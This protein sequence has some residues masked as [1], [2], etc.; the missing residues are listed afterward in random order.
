MF[1]ALPDQLTEEEIDEMLRL[2]D[3]NEDRKFDFDEFRSA[4]K[5]LVI[6]K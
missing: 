2:A 1:S 4:N 3:V 5:N 6:L